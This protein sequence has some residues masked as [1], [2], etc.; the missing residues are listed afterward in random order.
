M[1]ANSTTAENSLLIVFLIMAPLISLAVPAFLPLPSEVVPLILVFIPTILAILLTAITEG[2]KGVGVLLKKLAQWRIGLKWYIIALGL[3]LGLRLAMSLLALL[4]G[5]IPSIQLNTWSPQQFL[6]I[7]I[8]TLIGAVME[9][10]GWRGYALPRLLTHRSAFSSALIIGISWGVLHL[11]LIFPGQMNEGTSWIATILFLIGLSVILTWLFI[12]THHG[13]VVGIIYH[14]AQNYFVF[15]NGGIT[16]AESLW[17]MTAVTTVIA[18]ILI[19]IFGTN[20]QRNSVKNMP[21]V[22]ADR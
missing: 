11:G 1:K 15:V 6:I 3:A 19:V 16:S 4:F 14:A 2:G 13:V 9:E 8:F 22:G 7:G 21:L 5:W 12:Q 20:L 18:I 17:L 10:L